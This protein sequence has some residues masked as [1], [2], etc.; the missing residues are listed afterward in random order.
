[1]WSAETIELERGTAGITIARFLTPDDDA[2]SL[3]QLAEVRDLFGALA[4]E[5]QTRVIVLTGADGMF[6]RGPTLA[7]IQEM[8]ASPERIVSEMASARR[9]IQHFIDCDKPIVAAVEG[10]AV[11]LGTTL[12]LLCDIIVAGESAMFRDPHVRI[13]VAAGDA[14]TLIWPL[15]VGMARAKR[16]L[17]LAEPLAAATAHELGVVSELVPDGATTE[18]ALAYAERLVQMPVF[19][20]GATKAALNQWLR[21]GALCSSDFANALQLASQLHPDASEVIDTLVKRQGQRS[22]SS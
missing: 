9:T 14:G 22:G 8:R 10:H 16:H 4:A 15:L 21:L 11:G 3:R 17:L 12:A 18:R 1:M 7:A 19:A 13:G 20:L 6:F 2:A 5:T